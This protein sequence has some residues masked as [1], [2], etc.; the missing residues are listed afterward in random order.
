VSVSVLSS[1]FCV[2]VVRGVRAESAGM[3][4]ENVVVGLC[5]DPD[6]SISSCLPIYI[7]ACDYVF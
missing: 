7:Y 4:I 5:S 3:A 6:I 2:V 1:F